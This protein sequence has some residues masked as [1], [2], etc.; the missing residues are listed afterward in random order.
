VDDG[1]K[2]RALRAA[3]ERL[4]VR[5][6][7]EDLAD[8]LTGPGGFCIVKGDPTVILSPSAAPPERV[9]VLLRA[10]RAQDTDTIWLP[11]ALRA[12]L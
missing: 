9:A 1:S 12:L 6:R 7:D 10:L 2:E 8:E 3:L 11:P 4:G 5:I